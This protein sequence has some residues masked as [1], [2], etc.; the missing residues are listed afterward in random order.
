[1]ARTSEPSTAHRGALTFSWR[2]DRTTRAT[3]RTSFAGA[4]NTP[5]R[6]DDVRQAH[7]R[8]TKLPAR[9]CVF[10]QPAD[11]LCARRPLGHSTF[12]CNRSLSNVVVRQPSAIRNRIVRFTGSQ[13][14]AAGGT[15]SSNRVVSPCRS[16]S[17]RVHPVR[18]S[19]DVSAGAC[20]WGSCGNC[21]GLHR[22]S[23]LTSG[24]HTR[25]ACPAV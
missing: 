19:A 14:S 9:W 6:G 4:I 13:L 2:A 1:M 22:A 7:R 10:G 17:P 5:A 12:E 16:Y 24:R 18:R 20:R 8:W 11:V 15:E 21:C 3:V 23:V 25:C